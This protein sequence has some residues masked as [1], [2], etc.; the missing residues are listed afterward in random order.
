M[1]NFGYWFFGD[2]I[3]DVEEGAIDDITAAIA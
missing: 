2:D 1:N 3:A